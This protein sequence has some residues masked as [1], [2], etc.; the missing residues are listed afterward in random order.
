[1]FSITKLRHLI[2]VDRAGSIT[3][4][5]KSLNVTQS[6]VTKSVAEIE[7]E[8]GYSIFDRKARGVV[9]TDDGRE[10][11]SR[12]ARIVS[13]MQML[14]SDAKAGSQAREAVFRIGVC[15]SSI[16]GLLNRALKE[17]IRKNPDLCIHLISIPVE[18]GLKILRRGDID[19]LVGPEEVL[20]R[21]PDFTTEPVGS[22]HAALFC[23][24]GHPLAKKKKLKKKDLTE[25]SIITPD[26][27]STYA[28]SL[29]DLYENI[30][31]DPE[32]HLYVVESF[33]MVADIVGAT[34]LLATV[35]RGYADTS[36]FRSRFTRLEIDVFEPMALCCGYR[37]T[38]LPNRSI[39]S[40][41]SALADHS[42]A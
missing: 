36:A 3:A 28:D 32:R 12:A 30:G 15:P 1:M 5:A 4:A 38:R 19:V 29:R 6:S 33:P 16:E 10:F 13:D 26:L 40:F 9:A 11:I 24:K 35:G 39:R 17:M 41:L 42:P 34:D 31:A 20:A 22:L 7:R 21:E 37:S 25:Y 27:V 8:I 18:R 2:A 14:I 23:R